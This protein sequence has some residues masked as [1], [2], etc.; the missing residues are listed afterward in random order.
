MISTF[1]GVFVCHLG[2]PIPKIDHPITYAHWE[3]NCT[4]ENVH[5][6]MLCLFVF[7]SHIQLKVYDH[8]FTL[9]IHE[10]LGWLPT[11]VLWDLEKERWR[12]MISQGNMGQS[13]A[14]N[15]NPGPYQI[16][17]INESNSLRWIFNKVLIMFVIYWK[18]LFHAY[19]PTNM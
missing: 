16:K 18:C 10:K 8:D 15:K 6:D 19:C 11:R 14:F 1:F 2:F 12:K 17:I 3:Y 4:S 9:D 13:N 5:T 7:H